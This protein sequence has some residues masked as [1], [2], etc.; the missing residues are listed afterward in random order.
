MGLDGSIGDRQAHPVHG[1]GLAGCGDLLEPG[2]GA[3]IVSGHQGGERS[4]GQLLD[5]GTGRVHLPG[6]SC[7]DYRLFN[8]LVTS[9]ATRDAA[10][11]T[12]IFFYCWLSLS[13]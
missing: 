9:S 6:C 3:A 5:A 7:A 12:A 1:V 10:A 2:P 11:A 4:L 8:R 13:M